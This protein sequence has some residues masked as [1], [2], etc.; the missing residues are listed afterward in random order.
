MV[1][2]VRD[3]ILSES[4]HEWPALGME[5][6]S[7]SN[8]K[9]SVSIVE[10]AN[11]D[12]ELLDTSLDQEAVFVMSDEAMEPAAKNPKRLSHCSSSPD[13]RRRG[14]TQTIDEENIEDDFSLVSQPGSV[15]SMT[16]TG[17]S[18]KDAILSPAASINGDSEQT[19]IPVEGGLPQKSLSPQRMKS[20]IVVKPIHRCAKSMV[21]LRSLSQIQEDDDEDEVLGATDAMDFYHR[22]A[23]GAKG[24]SNG[25]KL[26]PDEAKR[27]QITM[28]NKNLQRQAN[29]S[30]G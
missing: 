11:E 30:R 28:H 20:K 13:L 18:F 16:T 9:K 4:H 27:K 22:K 19:E 3:T 26:R 1:E 17:F 2:A 15:L 23:L 14:L 7:E 21:D 10:D 24:R 5:A 25:L 6:L 12:W 29:T 8:G